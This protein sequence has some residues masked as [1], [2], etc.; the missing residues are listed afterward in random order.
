MSAK[1]EGHL[2]LIIGGKVE[3][4]AYDKKLP[5]GS[6]S[7]ALF[8][9]DRFVTNIVCDQYRRDLKDGG[10]GDGFHAFSTDIP[11][12]FMDGMEHTIDVR[13]GDKSLPNSPRT[14]VLDK[15]SSDKPL[16]PTV[17][18]APVKA[19]PLKKEA[20]AKISAP[21]PQQVEKI[22][23][24]AGNLE[25]VIGGQVEGWAWDAA[26]PDAHVELAVSVDGMKAGMVLADRLRQDL[27]KA[28]KGNGEHGFSWSIPDE[29]LDGQEHRIDVQEVTSGK[30]L[31][32]SPVTVVL[33]EPKPE[34]E[35]SLDGA[36]Y[37][38]LRG[39]V[40]N[41]TR[42][43]QRLSVQAKVNGKVVMTVPANRFRKDLKAAGK[44]N[45]NVAF[46]MKLQM[47]LD[48]SQRHEVEVSI[49][50][51]PDYQLKGSPRAI[52]FSAAKK[53]YQR[54]PANMETL[55]AAGIDAKQVNKVL[56]C[57][58]TTDYEAHLL[59]QR[60]GIKPTIV[61]PVYN[62]RDSLE[63]CLDSIFENTSQ[64]C[65]LVLIDDC[66][67]DPAIKEFL[68]AYEGRPSI[69]VLYNAK[70][71]GFSGTINKGIQSCDTDVII[72][73]SDTQVT[74]G[75]VQKMTSAAY[76]SPRVA[77][78]TAMSDNA[79]AFSVPAIGTNELIGALGRDEIGQLA[80]VTSKHI[81]P[82]VPTGN[83]FC[84]YIKREVIDDVGLFDAK[85]FPRGY[86]EENEFCMRAWRKGWKHIVDD[87]TIIFHERSASF[88]S[89]KTELMREGRKKV[90]AM[91]PEYS[92]L[93][94]EFP[95]SAR[96][97][98]MR[99]NFRE[100]LKAAQAQ[101]PEA[102]TLTK[103]RVLYV[104]HG[105]AIGG[106]PQ[107]NADLM[108]NMADQFATY[109]LTCNFSQIVLNRFVDG[110][111]RQLE[112]WQLPRRLSLLDQQR[113]DYDGVLANVLK[114]YSFD[115]VHIR[116]L[117]KHTMSLPKIAHT[118]GIPV[119]MSFHDFYYVC[120]SVHLLDENNVYCGGKCTKTKGDCQVPESD[121]R[122]P[123]L[124]NEW[125]HTW[126]QRVSETI[127]CAD[128]FVTTCEDARDVYVKNY[129]ELANARFMVIEHGRDFPQQ[130]HLAHVP[131]KDK[132]LRILLPGNL[133]VHK[134]VPFIEA[135]RELDKDGRIEFHFMGNFPD[136][137]A[138]L[139]VSHGRYKREE[140]NKIVGGIKPSFI[141]IFSI[142]P[143]TYC[144]TLSEA[145]ACGIPALVSNYGALGERVRK[146]GG[147]WVLDTDNPAAA[148]KNILKFAGS[149]ADYKRERDKAS[150]KNLRTTADMATDYKALYKTVLQSRRTFKEAAETERYADVTRCVPKIGY[151][152]T[153]NIHNITASAYIR[154][155][156]WIRHPLIAKYMEPKLL[157]L[158]A[159]L[160]E[161]AYDSLDA[162]VVQRTAVAPEQM[163]R[164]L[165][166]CKKRKL[167]VILEIDDNIFDLPEGTA[168]AV[169]YQ[170]KS[171]SLKT[172]AAA[173]DL[174]TVSTPELAEAVKKYAGRIEV[175]P[176]ALDERL[177]REAVNVFP[178]NETWTQDSAID[179]L[180]MGTRTHAEDLEL[181]EP[182]I[183]RLK[184]DYSLNVTLNVIGGE[185][186]K[187]ASETW[188]Q[189]IPIP[190]GLSKYS[191]F[192]RWL[193]SE[194]YRWTFA[195]APL[196]DN[197][198]N[199]SK[200]SLKYL[201]YAG[202]GLPAIFSKSPAYLAYI[203]DG[204]NGL[205]VDNTTDA[206]VEKIMFAV[207]NCGVMK[208][209][210]QAAQR[211]LWENH[212]IEAGAKRYRETLLGVF[213]G[214]A[215]KAKVA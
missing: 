121:A 48:P 90:Q 46:E 27:K 106:T 212:T 160:D 166:L 196:V 129:P 74:P 136:K 134:G 185:A 86:G 204:E 168:V 130:E 114:R 59:H 41:R 42:P 25:Q 69:T 2:D 67:P 107:T 175:L 139:G 137:Y 66:S 202:M 193:R 110:E 61:I 36:S 4:W 70:N 24:V 149:P 38:W 120:P 35:G 163:D 45:G 82:D 75:W 188:Y 210:S 203:R 195:V 141:G 97:S 80:A 161:A 22:S 11:E 98:E 148:Y 30:P 164:F 79:G 100:A 26:D 81:Y 145:W 201:D 115:L 3:G 85:T 63:R 105:D 132:P 113:D 34:F 50:G 5:D 37:P 99:D 13:V 19:A 128:A 184:E 14:V 91:H 112:V 87:S 15:L 140:F 31:A 144:H 29:F 178:R 33:A 189:P 176:N 109:C 127:A 152:V 180:Y 138:H 192:V 165:E 215:T 214:K 131:E 167:R 44:G 18:K 155:V 156:H 174:V 211:D 53:A 111:F 32:K 186:L 183:E 55:Q 6:L 16:T 158:D 28:G 135:I 103:P 151:L 150:L 12:K 126:R 23:K 125:I 8:I 206:W 47:P 21:A 54:G 117:F 104:L 123:Q 39:W 1:V 62:A 173:S 76:S 179:I 187:A 83:G 64:P 207:N 77:T 17:A 182:V 68:K 9:D 153:Q 197:S 200:S 181:L 191:E 7:V 146:H 143:E 133:E 205:L 118:M 157:N 93:I 58:V 122:F 72:L 108:G 194:A 116:H 199:R 190:Y 51:Y 71:L 43:V 101:S 154:V 169:E 78:V 198:I 95:E 162:V 20:P 171:K 208:E 49:I 142:W 94:G 209:I 92:S 172:L 177:W 213:E 88:G 84:M 57:G 10:I 73:N 52:E 96:M 40:W 65:N 89:D 56:E 124:K 60:S 170:D 159:F 119:I 102:K 147:G